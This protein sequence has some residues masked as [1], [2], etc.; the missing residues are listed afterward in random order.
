MRTFIWSR[1]LRECLRLIIDPLKDGISSVELIDH[2][3]NDL[4]VVNAARVSYN[5]ASIEYNGK[6]AKLIRYLMRNKHGSPFEHTCFTFRVRAPLFVVH[7]WER[8]RIASYNEESGRY[9]QLEAQFY[10][11]PNE[12]RKVREEKFRAD[13]DLYLS[14]LESGETKEQARDVLPMALYKSYWFTVNARALMNFLTLRTD[15]HAQEEIRRYANAVESFW[16]AV[17]PDTWAAWNEL[18]R[19]AP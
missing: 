2:M 5:K 14:L 8:H 11:R 10:V 17:M 4:S 9:I 13:Y 18:G 6:D 12:N 3:G 16:G 1:I 15:D 7:Q 19:I